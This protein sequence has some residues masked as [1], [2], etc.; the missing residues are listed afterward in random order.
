MAAIASLLAN[1]RTRRGLSSAAAVRELGVTRPTYYAWE[2]GAQ[3]PDLDNLDRIAQFTDEPRER[4][5]ELRL[6]DSGWLAPDEHFLMLRR[7][8]GVLRV[9][10]AGGVTWR[11]PRS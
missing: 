9:G 6:K 5:L 7:W 8:G 2:K 4:I 11:S 10:V 3:L 1:T